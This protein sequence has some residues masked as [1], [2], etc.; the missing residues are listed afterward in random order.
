MRLAFAGSPISAIPTLEWV[1]ESEHCLVKV[2]SQPSR[3]AGRGKVLTPTPVSEWATARG[4][5][6]VTVAKAQDLADHLREIDCVITVG[7]GLLLPENI[8]SIPPYGFLNLHFSLLPQWRGAAPV[9]RAIENQDRFTGVTVFR[10]DAGMDTGP[11]YSSARFAIDDDITSDELLHELAL[12]GPE[13][14]EIALNKISHGEPPTPQSSQGASRAHKLSREEGRINWS[15]PADQISAQIRAFTTNPGA[16]TSF[17]GQTLKIEGPIETDQQIP[18]GVIAASSQGL[19][20]G[21]AT[22]ALL[23]STCIP[24][25]KPRMDSRSW[26]NGARI[27]AGDKFE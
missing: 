4:V 3:P 19:L 17:R 8:L 10:L 1:A 15:R 7:Y 16:W 12:L 25:G 22:N 27:T 2:F 14:V 26:L 24:Q 20:V 21:T 11:I 5:E 23:I 9:Q 6:L 13:Q 18:H